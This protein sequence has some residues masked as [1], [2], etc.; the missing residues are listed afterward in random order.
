MEA[1]LWGLALHSL[2]ETLYMV[3][4]SG[5]L[6]FAM[7]LPLGALLFFTRPQGL[8]PRT[9]IQ[10]PLALMVNATRSLP[11]IILMIVLIPLTRAVVGSSIGIHAALVP[12]TLGALPFV[13]RLVE[14]AFSEIPRGTL[15]MALAYGA[16]PLQMFTR[17]LIPEALPSLIQ[18]ATL[19]LISLVGYSAMAG[20]MGG[21]GLGDLA[22]RYGYQRFHTPLMLLTAAIL[23][24]LVQG[25][26]S[27]GDFLA[28]NLDRKAKV[29]E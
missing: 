18:A 14:T 7:G 10:M 6:A 29:V 26:Q 23:I 28:R 15:D 13:A 16:T 24:A 4:V 25:I 3:S 5:L 17:I 9:N 2:G 27:I 12:L 11:F 19:C 21:G 1:K 20:A 22:I 8:Y